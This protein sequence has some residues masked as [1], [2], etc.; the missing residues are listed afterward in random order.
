MRLIVICLEALRLKEGV[1][2]S[3]VQYADDTLCIGEPTIENLWLLKA[4]LRGFEMTS[5]LKVNFH[6]SSLIGVNVQR[7]FM[8]AACKFLHCREGVVP[9]KYLG[10]SVGANSRKMSTWGNKYV[11]LGGRIVLLN[12]VLML[13]LFSTYHS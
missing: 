9:F 12:S 10:L 7:D 13:F 8:D 11:S 2:V 6:K 1:V 3:H 5:G 4:V